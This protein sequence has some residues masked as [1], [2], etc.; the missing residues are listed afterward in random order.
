M[1]LCFGVQQDIFLVLDEAGVDLSWENK[2]GKKHS[3]NRRRRKMEKCQA[4]NRNYFILRS[5][6]EI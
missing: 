4:E 3:S 5:F 1:L 6:T 2:S